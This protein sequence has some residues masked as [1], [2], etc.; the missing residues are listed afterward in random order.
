MP[1]M[2]GESRFVENLVAVS[3]ENVVVVWAV[4]VVTINKVAVSVDQGFH[5]S[6]SHNIG[7]TKV[8][9]GW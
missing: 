6:N 5:L 4:G 1:F 3:G 2:V 7:E 8:D 9:C